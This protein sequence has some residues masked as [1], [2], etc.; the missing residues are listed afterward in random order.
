MRINPGRY[1]FGIAIY[2]DGCKYYA[3]CQAMTWS[4][5]DLELMHNGIGEQLDINN[6]RFMIFV[7]DIQGNQVG[8]TLYKHNPVTQSPA[9][10]DIHEH[11]EY[12][13]KPK[14]KDSKPD[15]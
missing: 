3:N 8:V 4:N 6:N 14:K 12:Q 7:D 13:E 5:N 10:R 11:K 15:N 2:S 1:E 9:K